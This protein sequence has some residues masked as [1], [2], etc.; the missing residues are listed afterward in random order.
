MRIHCPHCKVRINV[1]P[2]H[3]RKP[4]AFATCPGCKLPFSLGEATANAL[5]GVIIPS[6]VVPDVVT[7]AEI[8]LLP[9]DPLPSPAQPAP[10]PPPDRPPFR[11]ACPGCGVAMNVAA[12]LAG[13]VI[14]CKRCNQAVRLPAHPQ[15]VVLDALPLPSISHQPSRPPELPAATNPL[16]V[17]SIVFGSMALVVIMLPC[18]GWIAAVWLGAIGILTGVF[19]FILPGSKQSPTI[20]LV[21]SLLAVVIAQS[22]LNQVF[23]NP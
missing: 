23:K 12:R 16:G 1:P 10:F 17:V 14:E 13:T 6:P 9:P 18:L 3:S 22:L 4:G 19:G 11:V 7:P 20:G 5:A 2:S 21:L 8:V 15:D